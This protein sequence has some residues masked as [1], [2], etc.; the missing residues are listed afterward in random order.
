[1]ADHMKSLAGYVVVVSWWGTSGADG[2]GS[3]TDRILPDL[4]E[5]AE[6][7]GASIAIHL[8]PYTGM[9]AQ[10]E[11]HSPTQHVR[12]TPPRKNHILWFWVS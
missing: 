9:C 6:K 12:F 1:M 2:E 4:L 10:S 3:R 5:A 11:L 8:E 7:H